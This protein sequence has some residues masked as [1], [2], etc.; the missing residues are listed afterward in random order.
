MRAL[1]WIFPAI[2]SIGK[3]GEMIKEVKHQLGVIASKMWKDAKIVGDTETEDKS[4]LAIMRK[5]SLL[6]CRLSLV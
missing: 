2:L 5:V 1:F 3:K 4:L 6:C